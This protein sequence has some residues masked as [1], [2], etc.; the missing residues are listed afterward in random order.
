M[1]QKEEGCEEGDGDS[2]N[3]KQEPAH[4]RPKEQL[5]VFSL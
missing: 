4:T 3:I 1:R 2:H 5:A